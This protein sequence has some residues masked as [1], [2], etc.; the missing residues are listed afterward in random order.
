MK[1]IKDK[2][3]LSRY[4]AEAEYQNLF[5]RE[6][7]KI[8][9]LKSAVHG[10]ILMQQ[11]TRPEELLYLVRGKCSVSCVLPN[12]KT[13]LLKTLSIPG[14]IGEMELVSPEISPMTVRTLEECELLSFP[15][16]RSRK[17]LLHDTDFLRKLCILLGNKERQSVLR[18]FAASGYPLDKRL[19]A[20]IL[21]QR[22]GPF[23]RIR[24]IQT[25]ETLGVS[26]R[27]LETVL[28]RFIQSGFLSKDHFTYRIEDEKALQDLAR[29]ITEMGQGE[30]P[31]VPYCNRSTFMIK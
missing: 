1:T 9:I 23:F 12:G 28:Q 20:F 27:H 4:L 5:P 8:A 7:D 15:A 31:L 29:E 6:M 11:G 18:F 14:I 22:E 13:I 21:E 16:G 30:R 24:K 3:K 25:A 26:Y 2:K 19:A 17:I 10:E